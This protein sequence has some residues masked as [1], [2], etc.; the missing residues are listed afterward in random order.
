MSPDK[1]IHM[2][3]QIAQFHARQPEAEA[4]ANIASHLT[5]FWDP[6]MRA[7]IIAFSETDG[8]RLTPAARRAVDQLSAEARAKA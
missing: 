1:L 3:N 6:R 7:A 8:E 2:I 5:R 4:A